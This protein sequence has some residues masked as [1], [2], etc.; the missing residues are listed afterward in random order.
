MSEYEIWEFM[1]ASESN[2]PPGIYHISSDDWVVDGFLV[3]LTVDKGHRLVLMFKIKLGDNLCECDVCSYHRKHNL[4]RTE[5]YEVP[6]FVASL[7]EPT[8]NLFKF[9]EKNAV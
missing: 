9:L 5:D 1:K 2:Y 8:D 4:Y 7:V 6:P 3:G